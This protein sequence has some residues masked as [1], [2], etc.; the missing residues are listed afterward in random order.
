MDRA[1]DLAAVDALQ[2][3]AGD[4]QVGVPKLALDDNEGDAFVRHLDR[5]GVPELMFVP[6][7]AQA[8]ICRPLGYADHAW[9]VA[10]PVG[11]GGRKVGL[12]R[13]IHGA[14]RMN[15]ARENRSSQ[16]R[17]FLQGATRWAPRT[18]MRSGAFGTRVC[19]PARAATRYDHTSC[20][21]GVKRNTQPHGVGLCRRPSPRNPH[22][23]RR[24]S[25]ASA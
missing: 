11:F 23:T 14:P 3:D 25:N 2:V 19:Q 1:D 18:A 20:L 7:S 5:M 24:L 17:P 9:S 10:A 8:P 4:A 13:G 12:I 21:A 22:H 16:R 6:T 15:G